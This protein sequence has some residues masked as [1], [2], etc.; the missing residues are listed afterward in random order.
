MKKIIIKRTLFFLFMSFALFFNACHENKIPTP[1]KI[2][3]LQQFFDH[4]ERVIPPFKIIQFKQ[5]K[6]DS[7]GSC[8]SSIHP[9][10]KTEFEK[11][12]TNTAIHQDLEECRYPTDSLKILALEIRF[13]FYENGIYFDRLDI[14]KIIYQ[15]HD[16]RNGKPI[17]GFREILG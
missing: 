1:E 11:L 7:S 17:Q 9:F 12:E 15:I 8:L 13:H 3:T 5:C 2:E 4:M 16:Y 14:R 6:L 10:F